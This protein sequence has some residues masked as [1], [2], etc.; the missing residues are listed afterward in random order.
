MRSSAS[1]TGSSCAAKCPKVT[2][3]R[4]TSPG[5]TMSKQANGSRTGTLKVSVDNRAGF[6]TPDRVVLRVGVPESWKATATGCTVRPGGPLPC[7][8]PIIAKGATRTATIAL[9]APAGSLPA[10][11]ELYVSAETE[12]GGSYPSKVV[13][14]PAVVPITR[15]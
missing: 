7:T 15:S 5:L 12:D 1:R 11:A 8:L 9:T 3:L 10:T 14:R 13:Q 4:V 6:A 2:D